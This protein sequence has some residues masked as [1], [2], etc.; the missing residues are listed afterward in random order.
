MQNGDSRKRSY[1]TPELTMHGTLEQ[2]TKQLTDKKPGTGD[3]MI[4]Q[5]IALTNTS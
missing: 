4:F 5:G 1:T 3:G 2:L